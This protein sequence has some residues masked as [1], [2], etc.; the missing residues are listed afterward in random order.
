MPLRK[1]T[2]VALHLILV[3][4]MG[5]AGVVAPVAAAEEAI[6]AIPAE[7]AP[8]DMPCDS[9]GAMHEAPAD[10][11]CAKA[12]CSLVNCLG[13]AACL[14][15]MARVTAHVPTPGRF[16]SVDVHFVPTGIIDTPLRPPI[17]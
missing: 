4:S 7:A 12:H 5:L 2:R 13:A 1:L 15:E 11:P 8:M 10:D 3:L 16:N 14:P 9:M 17:A 6:A